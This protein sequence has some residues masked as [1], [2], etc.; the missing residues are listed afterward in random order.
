MQLSDL[1][2]NTVLPFLQLSLPITIISPTL[3]VFQ[4]RPFPSFPW[5]VLR[6]S[7]LLAFQE[8][9]YVSR[10]VPRATTW[11]P[12]TS[13]L[14]LNLCA[15]TYS[16]DSA[17]RYETLVPSGVHDQTV[18]LSFP[19]LCLL[20]PGVREGKGRRILAQTIEV[21]ADIIELPGARVRFVTRCCLDDRSPGLQRQNVM[22][23]LAA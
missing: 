9:A 21:Q 1:I 3:S 7:L 6:L 17:A 13:L 19:V 2:L 12:L 16:P 22:F 8:C 15:C 11:K 18:V 10:T 14:Y 4:L 20:S 5:M 23:L